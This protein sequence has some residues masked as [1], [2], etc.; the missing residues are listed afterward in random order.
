M[1]YK[2]AVNTGRSKMSTG[3]SFGNGSRPGFVPYVNG[4]AVPNYQEIKKPKTHIIEGTNSSASSKNETQAHS[5]QVIFKAA[6]VFICL[7]A[8][9]GAVNITLTSAT[10]AAATKAEATQKDINSAREVGKS[11]EVKY[12]TL[13]NTS[14]V[15]EKAESLGMAV[16]DSVLKINLKKDVVATD[17]DGNLLLAKSL[18]AVQAS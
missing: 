8:L 15:K 4:S 16:S 13:T 11:L 18:S 5:F 1:N 7:I 2:N 9:I 6:L 3:S 14:S 12:G 17:N 10:M